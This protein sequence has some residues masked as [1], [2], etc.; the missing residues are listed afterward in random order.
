MQQPVVDGQSQLRTSTYGKCFSGGILNDIQKPLHGGK[1]LFVQAKEKT[2]DT[3]RI[4]ANKATPSGVAAVTER[5][6]AGG[7]Q[8]NRKR[9]SFDSWLPEHPHTS[10]SFLA[11]TIGAKLNMEKWADGTRARENFPGL[12]GSK[13][14]KYCPPGRPYETLAMDVRLAARSRWVSGAGCRAT[15]ERAGPV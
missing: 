7:S 14:G 9:N 13:E 8:K 2:V 1:L 4:L 3:V 6:K 15:D 10:I 5:R 12:R 11:H